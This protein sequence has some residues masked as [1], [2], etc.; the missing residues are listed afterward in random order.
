MWVIPS[1]VGTLTGANRTYANRNRVSFGLLPGAP[2]V[3]PIGHSQAS[4][5]AY[6]VRCECCPLSA[7]CGSRVAEG[8]RMEGRDYSLRRSDGKMQAHTATAS[9][10]F[11]WR[12]FLLALA[13]SPLLVA[14]VLYH[15]RNRLSSSGY[16][17]SSRMPANI[18][19]FNRVE[20]GSSSSPTHE[21][22]KMAALA[23]SGIL[24][25]GVSGTRSSLKEVSLKFLIFAPV[26]RPRIHLV[27]SWSR[28]STHSVTFIHHSLLPVDQYRKQFTGTL[29][30]R[31]DFIDAFRSDSNRSWANSKKI[32]PL[33]RGI[34]HPKFRHRP[35][36]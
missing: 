3:P 20:S 25:K 12:Q 33:Q 26:D 11:V 1:S 13:R 10:S 27:L 32:A 35:I 7:G 16:N 29:N 2:P 19:R 5:V 6:P 24:K 14:A 36:S 22:Q 23:I 8:Q 34:K 17:C 30:F 9:R 4:R 15:P 31:T 28:Q 18:L 21:C